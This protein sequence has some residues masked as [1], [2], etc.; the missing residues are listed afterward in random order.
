[1]RNIS[2]F[3]HGDND[4][5]HCSLIEVFPRL[6]EG[7]GYELLKANQSRMLEVIPSPSEGYTVSYLKDVVG[8]GRIY[9]RPIQRDLSLEPIVLSVSVCSYVCCI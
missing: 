6:K 5:L 8:Q 2:L 7:G 3:Q 1:M 4:D 9:V